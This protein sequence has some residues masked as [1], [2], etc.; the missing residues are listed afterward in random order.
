[1]SEFESEIGLLKDHASL[2]AAWL[3]FLSPKNLSLLAAVGAC[4]TSLHP[5]Y[6][7]EEAHI[8]FDTTERDLR[9]VI[10]ELQI[11]PARDDYAYEFLRPDIYDNLAWAGLRLDRFV[12]IKTSAKVKFGIA[13]PMV[14][15]PNCFR[16][17]HQ[18]RKGMR[19]ARL[20]CVDHRLDK[21]RFGGKR[22]VAEADFAEE[23]D[24]QHMFAT[25]L[26]VVEAKGPE[27]LFT[28]THDGFLG[29]LVTAR[30]TQEAIL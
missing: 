25:L 1:M 2:C 5:N 27:G 12:N 7:L 26:S 16:L 23:C 11:P 28:I 6:A 22:W 18:K 3:E 17:K 15:S 21:E 10:A 4:C 13:Q 29:A 30:A 19:W 9:K 8:K 24:R 20:Y 14:F